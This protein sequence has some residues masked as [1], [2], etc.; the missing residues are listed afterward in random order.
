[1]ACIFDLGWMG[2]WLPATI[3]NVVI[4]CLLIGEEEREEM[5]H[6]GC[7]LNQIGNT[8]LFYDES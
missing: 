1:M 7:N 6:V 5:D 8:L 2:I 4:G 3:C